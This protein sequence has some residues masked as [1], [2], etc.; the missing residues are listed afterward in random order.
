[1]LAPAACRVEN[2]QGDKEDRLDGRSEGTTLD[3]DRHHTDVTTTVVNIKRREPFDVYIGRAGRG[4]DGYY[5]NPIRLDDCADRQE[6]IDRYQAYFYERIRTDAEFK[7]R[8]LA[9]RGKRLGCWCHPAKCHGHVI[10][11]YVD[12]EIR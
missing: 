7:H 5:G 4:Y 3:N 12:A 2:D 10:A 1:M 9:L 11:E 6:C 8:V